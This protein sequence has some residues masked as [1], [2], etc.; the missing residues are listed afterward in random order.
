MAMI[1]INGKSYFVKKQDMIDGITFLEI[2]KDF[3][4]CRK[5]KE[6]VIVNK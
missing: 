5:G 4:K 1:D 2:T 6:I 3:I